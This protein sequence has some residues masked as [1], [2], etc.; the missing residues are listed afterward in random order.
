MSPAIIRAL[1]DNSWLD[2]PREEPDVDNQSCGQ[3]TRNDFHCP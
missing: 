3:L 1:R 2:A